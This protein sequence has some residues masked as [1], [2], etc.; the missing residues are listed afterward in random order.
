MDEQNTP[1]R[2]HDSLG[3]W[4]SLAA[5]LQERRLDDRLREIGLTRITWCILL[6]LANEGLSQPSELADFVGIDRTATSRALRQMEEAGLLSR[7]PGTDDRRT[8]RIGLTPEG[9]MA[10][11]QAIPFALQNTAVMTDRLAPGEKEQ[12]LRLLAKVSEGDKGGLRTF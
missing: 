10:L 7:D 6:G 2:L 3:Y 8:R 4:L 12:L 1:Y 5:R 11:A 9:H